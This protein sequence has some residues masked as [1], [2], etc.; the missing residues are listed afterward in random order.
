MSVVRRSLG[1]LAMATGLVVAVVPAA[2]ASGT[3]LGLPDFADMAVDS[4]HKRVFVTGGGSA[5]SV[6]VTDFSGRVVKRIDNQFGAA[7]LALSADSKTIY[8]ALST[9]DAITALDTD[10]L[11]ET[12]RFG[13]GAQ[14]CPTHLTRTGSLVWF[15]YGCGDVWNGRIGKLDTAATPP[16]VS[17]DQQG[18][19]TFQQA[20]LVTSPA[21]D[22]GPV[23]AGQ[24]QLSLSNVHVF[25]V[26]DG[27]LVVGA[28]GGA[29]GSN[30]TDV[31]VTPDGQT[32]MTAAGSTDRVNA[33]ATAD[34]AGRG[35]YFTGSYPNAVAVSPNGTYLASGI[36]TTGDDITVHRLGSTQPVNR[37]DLRSGTLAARGLAWSADGARL[38]AISQN[39]PDQAPSLSVVSHPTN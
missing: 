17:G 7:G 6:V 5:N 35:G 11:V 3:A 26:Q 13:T 15:G 1:A 18:E 36:H 12:G 32:M 27:M 2:Q 38:F 28:S 34:L 24:L 39:A 30:L 29:V 16:A 22:A 37:I 31:S 9:G 4:V 21:A 23:V 14:T 25:S 19:A 33:F 8:V 10:R 20:P